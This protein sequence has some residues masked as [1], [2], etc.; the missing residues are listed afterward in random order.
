MYKGDVTVSQD[1]LPFVLKIGSALQIHGI[2]F[3]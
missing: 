3:F 2:F 1:Q